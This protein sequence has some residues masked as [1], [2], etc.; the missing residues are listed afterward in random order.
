[1]TQAADLGATPNQ[2]RTDYRAAI[3]NCFQAVAT[4][5]SGG[6]APAT[7][8]P[9]MLWFDTS[10]NVI[11]L[12]NS[13]NTAWST[14]GTLSPFSWSSISA[15]SGSLATG[16]L[17]GSSVTVTGI[18]AG[19]T[20]VDVTLVAITQN[21]TGNLALQL[22]TSGGLAT[23]GYASSGEEIGAVTATTGTSLILCL[24]MPSS[25]VIIGTARL[26]L[27]TSNRWSMQAI[28][29][30]TAAS[31][32]NNISMGTVVLSGELDRIAITS[33]AAMNGGI[34]QLRWYK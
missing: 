6:S 21:A 2:S 10:G 28:V 15:T 7:T 20:A 17:S 12:R 23:S 3:N 27:S 5:H 11:K 18:P 19:T 29:G 16:T 9:Y 34:M 13:T 31:A 32:N 25:S 4:N 30:S 33:T 26:F 14:V 8:Y 24:Q 1:M 22:G